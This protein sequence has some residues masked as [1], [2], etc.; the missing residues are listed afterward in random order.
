MRLQLY[1]SITTLVFVLSW[2]LAAPIAAQA[3]AKP[4]AIKPDAPDRYVVQRGDT[5]WS[6]SERYLDAPWRWQ[7]LWDLNKDQIKDPNRIYPGN[8]LVLDRQRAQLALG[9]TVKLSPRVRAESTGAAAIPSIPPNIIEPF[10]ARPL[11]VERDGLD[12]APTIVA[13]RGGRVIIGLGD[14]AFAKGVSGAKDSVWYVY[15]RGVPLVDPDTKQTLGYVATHLGS[16]RLTRTDEPATLEIIAATQEISVGDKLIAAGRPQPVDYAPR[17]PGKP[18]HGRIIT[19]YG[20]PGQLGE[21]GPQFVIG[22]NRGQADG[23]EVGHV[24]A[25]YRAGEVIASGGEA[26]LKTPEERYGLVMVFRVFERVSAALV[27]KVS[28]AV[29]MF[30]VV[31][32]P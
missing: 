1:K 30:D 17:A 19:I 25:L 22:L 29:Q 23:L 2:L 21:A 27:M 32:N 24:L 15:R 28:D 18:V 9:D 13:T 8:V 4:P 11:V 10:L 12:N 31:R 5:L 6:I 3:P 14:V 26:P 7:E 20:S 16:A